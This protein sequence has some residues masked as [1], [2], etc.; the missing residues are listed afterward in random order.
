MSACVRAFEGASRV[1]GGQSSG[2]REK[3]DEDVC[4]VNQILVVL[5]MLVHLRIGNSV[6][7]GR[8]HLTSEFRVRAQ[9][10]QSGCCFE[11]L[12][13]GGPEHR[14][15]SV[16]SETAVGA[17]RFQPDVVLRRYSHGDAREEVIV[18]PYATKELGDE[19]PLWPAKLLATESLESAL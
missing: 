5:L 2:Q 12:S 10:P 7:G 11:V 19:L 8:L 18:A 9:Y 17:L 3:S 14:R 13:V 6:G 16:P 1:C 4:T 15:K